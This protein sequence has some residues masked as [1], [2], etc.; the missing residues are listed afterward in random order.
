MSHLREFDASCYL[1]RLVIAAIAIAAIALAAV[2]I[3]GG[4]TTATAQPGDCGEGY[5]FCIAKQ[6]IPGTNQR[7][8]FKIDYQVAEGS[9]PT[10]Q[11]IYEDAT[12]YLGNGENV[13]VNVAGQ[14]I[15]T[16]IPEPGW[17]LVDVDCEGTG[18]FYYEYVPNGVEVGYTIG[19][20]QSFLNCVW[21]NRQVQ[22]QQRPN[23]NLGGLFAD[24]PNIPQQ[25]PAP[26]AP[27]AVAGAPVISPPNTGDGGLK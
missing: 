1:T 11:L 5:R 4:G 23:L 21:T 3:Q 19:T 7:F 10:S 24:K 13:G 17:E 27:S 14:V 22:E 15:V 9:Q 6:T 26:A 12:Y 16:E 8:A 2:A 18:D 25:G 20:E